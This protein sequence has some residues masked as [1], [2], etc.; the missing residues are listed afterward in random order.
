MDS[1]SP[2]VCRICVTH[3]E[4]ISLMPSFAGSNASSISSSTWGGWI[5]RS[6]P[7]ASPRRTGARRGQ[8]GAGAA[9]RSAGRATARLLTRPRGTE[10]ARVAGADEDEDATTRARRR[11]GAARANDAGEDVRVAIAIVEFARCGRG[12][13]EGAKEWGRGGTGWVTE[14]LLEALPLSRSVLSE[15]DFA[16]G[17]ASG[18]ID[19]S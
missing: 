11:R 2:Y 14:S 6:G 12:E 19:E 9:A 5:A 15:S 10:D 18:R 1:S 13:P 16:G 17:V 7:A 4:M 3:R 8:R